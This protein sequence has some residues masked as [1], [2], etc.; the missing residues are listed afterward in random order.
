MYRSSLSASFTTTKGTLARAG[1]LRAWDSG[2]TSRR[3]ASHSIQDFA[4]AMPSP[5]KSEGMTAAIGPRLNHFEHTMAGL[6]VRSLR[7]RGPKSSVSSGDTGTNASGSKTPRHSPRDGAVNADHRTNAFTRVGGP[8]FHYQDN[9]PASG[10]V[11][12]ALSLKTRDASIGFV[13][14][15]MA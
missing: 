11:I 5:P 14:A 8:R 4:V 7:S 12:V 1:V 9:R 6:H 3:E 2:L 15:W 10:T 13:A